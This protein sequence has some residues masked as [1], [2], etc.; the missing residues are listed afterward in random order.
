MSVGPGQLPRDHLSSD[1]GAVNQGPHVINAL[2][3]AHVRLLCVITQASPGG[4]SEQPLPPLCA[5]CLVVTVVTM[6]TCVA[7][8]P[9]PHWSHRAS[10]T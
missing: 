1:S 10:F 5:R 3:G 6:L 4:D 8:V 9:G 2:C 7:P